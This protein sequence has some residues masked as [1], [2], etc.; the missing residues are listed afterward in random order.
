[1]GDSGHGLDYRWLMDSF[2][3][4]ISWTIGLYPS[5]LKIIWIQRLQLS[6]VQKSA[7]NSYFLALPVL[8]YTR[9]PLHLLSISFTA[10]NQYLPSTTD[11]AGSVAF[12]LSNTL[13][14]P[15]SQQTAP[16]GT[17]VIEINCR[18]KRIRLWR[19]WGFGT[20]LYGC[21]QC[22]RIMTLWIYS[23]AVIQSK[24]RPYC[25]PVYFSNNG[26]PWQLLF[27]FLVLWWGPVVLILFE[28]TV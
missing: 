18:E 3:H 24:K 26:V 14:R 4:G 23:V 20:Q 6:P 25:L 28:L 11:S 8:S 7:A 2:L 12:Q 19:G 9:T 17:V 21:K 1:M 22:R 15:S 5:S 13:H 27:F 10:P 16:S